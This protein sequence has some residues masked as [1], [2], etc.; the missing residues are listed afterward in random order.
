MYS[1]CSSTKPG[2]YFEEGWQRCGSGERPFAIDVWGRIAGGLSI[3][4]N[5]VQRYRI[6]TAKMKRV[7][8]RPSCALEGSLDLILLGI[9]QMCR[10]SNIKF[11]EHIA[12]V[13]ALLGHSLAANPMNVIRRDDLITNHDLDRS[14]I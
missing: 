7:R 3:L 13:A 2:R 5:Y 8:L 4:Q 9:I 11:N 14:I 6:L 12:L 10:E 1:F